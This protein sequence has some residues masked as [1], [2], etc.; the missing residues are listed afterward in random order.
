[1]YARC[2]K[3]DMTE[4]LSDAQLYAAHVDGVCYAIPRAVRRCA[5]RV[6]PSAGDANDMGAFVDAIFDAL[7]GARKVYSGATQNITRRL[8]AHQ[9]DLLPE[10]EWSVCHVLLFTSTVELARRLETVQNHVV[11]NTVEWSD[12]RLVAPN[13]GRSLLSRGLRGPADSGP[14]PLYALYLLI[15]QW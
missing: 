4:P 9:S 5:V 12:G 1:M 15:R 14:M 8:I 3:D 11:S 10:E 6:A 2:A 13:T 7:R